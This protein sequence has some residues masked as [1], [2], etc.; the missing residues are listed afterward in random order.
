MT[1][2]LGTRVQ[3][4]EM[5]FLRPVAGRMRLEM[6]RNKGT[7]KSLGEQPLLLQIEKSQLRWFGMCGEGLE[8]GRQSNCF[9]RNDPEEESGSAKINRYK[10]TEGVCSKLWSSSAEAPTVA[11][12]RER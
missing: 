4:A 6:V 8:K 11:Q 9:L 12:D 5:G 7:W 3:A 2:K 10:Y 1:E